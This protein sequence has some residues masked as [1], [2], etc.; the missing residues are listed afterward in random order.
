MWI[1]SPLVAE[2]VTACPIVRHGAIADVQL[3]VSLPVFDTKRS[4][5]NAS[6]GVAS[7]TPAATTAA[8]P[9]RPTCR[10]SPTRPTRASDR[11]ND[12]PAL[13]RANASADLEFPRVRRETATPDETESVGA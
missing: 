13:G 1:V 7:R 3:V 8:S 5:A 9:V 4:V 12:S 2:A 11:L 6:P 10:S